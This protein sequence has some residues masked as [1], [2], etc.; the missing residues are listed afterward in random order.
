[1]ALHFTL[2]DESCVSHQSTAHPNFVCT[3][4]DCSLEPHEACTLAQT[5]YFSNRVC[6]VVAKPVFMYEE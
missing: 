6:K 3:M 5:I 1:M 2:S 4:S